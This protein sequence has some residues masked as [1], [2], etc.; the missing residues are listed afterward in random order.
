VGDQLIAREGEVGSADLARSVAHERTDAVSA[1]RLAHEH[2]EARVV[3]TEAAD[4]GRHRVD[5]E[6]RERGDLQHPGDELADLADGGSRGV[7]RA[8]RLARGSDESFAGGREAQP[9]PD[10]VEELGAYLAL[11]RVQS[12]RERGLRDVQPPRSARHATVLDDRQEVA[13]ASLIHR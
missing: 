8:Q 13:Q 9:A 11:E 5:G 6:R 10:A 7:E 2:L 4:Q 3:F 12:L 1:L